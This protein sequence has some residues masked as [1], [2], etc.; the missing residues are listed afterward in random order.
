MRRRSHHDPAAAHVEASTA[1][2]DIDLSRPVERAL[3]ALAADWWS[4]TE[5]SRATGG[6][7][8]RDMVT[9]M[10]KQISILRHPSRA[11]Q[12]YELIDGVPKALVNQV[13]KFERALLRTCPMCQRAVISPTGPAGG[14]PRKYCSSPCKQ[15]AYRARKKSA[16]PPRE[17]SES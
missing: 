16:V 11:H 1:A 2:A 6:K 9:D 15:A 13:E 12:L 3:L 7:V 5:I 8:W 4:D 10:H 14:R 17:A